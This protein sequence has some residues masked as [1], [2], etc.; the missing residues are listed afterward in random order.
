MPNFEV[1]MAFNLHILAEF[2]ESGTAFA[3]SSYRKILESLETGDLQAM[4]ET[5]RALF[6]SIPY[7]LHM[8]H[9]SYYHSIFYAMVNLLGFEIESEAP[10]SGGRI[11][12]VLEL[13]DKVYVIEFKYERCPP[14]AAP[15]TKQR[16]I[17]KA[18]DNGMMQIKDK[19]YAN[20]YDG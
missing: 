11:D 3:E 10:V 6:A 17:R 8:K 12:A 14:V 15:E 4:L 9:E 18:L 20:K 16:L 13:G 7:Q 19:G 1:R 5:M 2:A